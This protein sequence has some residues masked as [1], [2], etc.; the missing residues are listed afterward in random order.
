MNRSAEGRF[1][2]SKN[3]QLAVYNDNGIAKRRTGM[4]NI[5][6]SQTTFE[7]QGWELSAREISE[8]NYGGI[9]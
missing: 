8:N 4:I 6:I 3:G 9:V 5:E 1:D 2:T 7:R